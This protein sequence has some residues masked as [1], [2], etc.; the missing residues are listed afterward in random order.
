MPTQLPANVVL[1]PEVIAAIRQ[2]VRET[3]GD[4]FRSYGGG[5][6][7]AP[8]V[9]HLDDFAPRPQPRTADIRGTMVHVAGPPAVTFARRQGQCPRCDRRL[10]L[11]AKL[12]GLPRVDSPDLVVW[13]CAPCANELRRL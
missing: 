5:P 10:H 8:A 11:N 2:V 1:E 6:P 4:F 9:G 13:V 3:L 7:T 12:V